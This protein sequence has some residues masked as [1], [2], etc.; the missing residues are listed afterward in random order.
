MDFYEQ[1]VG[2]LL[3]TVRD[4][5]RYTA[6]VDIEFCTKLTE[7]SQRF[8]VFLAQLLRIQCALRSLCVRMLET[9]SRHGADTE[10]RQT[11]NPTAQQSGS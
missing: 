8:A 7:I 5:I 1:T 10:R 3:E 6:T 4:V 2:V 9:M 11:D